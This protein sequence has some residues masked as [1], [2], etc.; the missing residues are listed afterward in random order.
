MSARAEPILQE[1]LDRGHHGGSL[2]V[3]F[4]IIIRFEMRRVSD[5]RGTLSFLQRCCKAARAWIASGAAH[6]LS[7]Y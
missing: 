1:L 6:R 5:N 7:L 2:F 3:C 4:K